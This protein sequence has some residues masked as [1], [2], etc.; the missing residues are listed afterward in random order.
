MQTMLTPCEKFEIHAPK[1]Y[2][3]YTETPFWRAFRDRDNQISGA[4]NYAVLKSL[5]DSAASIRAVEAYYDGLRCVP[6]FMFP[7]D[8]VPPAKAWDTLVRAGY[9]FSTRPAVRMSWRG[10]PTALFVPRRCTIVPTGTSLD[11][12]PASMLLEYCDGAD[13]VLKL[14]N[15]QLA[16]GARGFLAVTPDGLPVSLCV[17]L[18]YAD[19]FS[20][21]LL[22]TAK[23]Q[24]KKGYGAAALSAALAWT[25]APEQNYAQVFLECDTQDSEARSLFEKAGFEGRE[26]PV[27]CAFQGLVPPGWRACRGGEL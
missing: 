26:E 19:G 24:R 9:M 27:Y 12:V 3:E 16:G 25:R 10:R 20:I 8:S 4:S 15:R 11:G 6:K 17:G 2:L 1:K 22:Y 5:E 21:Q 23:A 14:I 7:A 13:H 18:G